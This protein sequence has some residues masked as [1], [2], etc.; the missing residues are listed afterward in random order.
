MKN[1]YS[2]LSD[3]EIDIEVTKKLG[4]IEH[5]FVSNSS[6]HLLENKGVFWDVPSND[7]YNGFYSKKGRKF[8]VCYDKD[9]AFKLMIDNKLDLD[10]NPLT[11]SWSCRKRTNKKYISSLNENPCRAI[12]ETFLLMKDAENE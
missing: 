7:L 8:S 3:L 9:N 12:A 1:K 6:N 10:F 2:G 5:M 4:L 11:N